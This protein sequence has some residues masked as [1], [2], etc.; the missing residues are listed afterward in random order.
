MNAAHQ[1]V[2]A[3]KKVTLSIQ[4]GSAPDTTDLTPVPFEL[5]FICG[6]G[7]KGLTLFERQLIDLPTGGETVLKLDTRN[8]HRVFEY[9]R[10]PPMIFPVHLDVFYLCVRVD[11]VEAADPREVVKQMAAL[12]N[13]DDH[14]CGH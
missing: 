11:S 8:M 13:C 2:A 6:L 4:A 10:L 5:G 1:P 14:C 3:M 12:A 9:I 7:T